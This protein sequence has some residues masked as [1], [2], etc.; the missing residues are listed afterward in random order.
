LFRGREEG[1]R[2]TTGPGLKEDERPSEKRRPELLRTGGG[3]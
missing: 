2:K 1:K 3:K